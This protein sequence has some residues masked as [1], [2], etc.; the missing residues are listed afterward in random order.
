[1]EDVEFFFREI[2]P[3]LNSSDNLENLF[4]IPMLYF[5]WGL[6][7]HVAGLTEELGVFCA[8]LYVGLRS[9]HSLIHCSYNRIMHRFTA[10]ASSTLLL[11]VHWIRTF[12]QL[13]N[14]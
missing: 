6:I 1:M 5:A 7:V 12:I 4:E 3:G 8:Y 13:M 2:K 10:Y 9:I 14:M 11:M